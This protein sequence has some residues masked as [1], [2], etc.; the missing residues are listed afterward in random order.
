[1]SLQFIGQKHHIETVTLASSTP[2]TASQ[3]SWW[4]ICYRITRY[5]E[6]F[7]YCSTDKELTACSAVS[8]HHAATIRTDIYNTSS[9]DKK[10]QIIS[11]SFN[12]IRTNYENVFKKKSKTF[13]LKNL[14]RGLEKLQKLTKYNEVLIKQHFFYNVLFPSQD[15]EV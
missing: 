6:Y 12:I 10:P 9:K 5:S 7:F 3:C 14:T 2:F 15:N 11:W 4:G 8:Q 1:M 13:F